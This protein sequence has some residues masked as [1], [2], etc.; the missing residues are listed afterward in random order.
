MNQTAILP[1]AQQDQ[2][3]VSLK[4]IEAIV[5]LAMA[6]GETGNQGAF[7]EFP[8]TT[9]VTAMQMVIEEVMGIRSLLGMADSRDHSAA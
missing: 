1:L 8:K 2:I 9:L 7:P 3:I 6:A 4:K 5:R